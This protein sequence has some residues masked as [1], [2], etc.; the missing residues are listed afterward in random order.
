M[1][2]SGDTL[3]ITT[4]SGLSLYNLRTHQYRR[5]LY[6]EKDSFSVQ[7]NNLWLLHRVASGEVIVS[8]R[9]LSRYDAAK[10][11]FY[12]KRNSKNKDSLY[13]Y[14]D[15]NASHYNE[16]GKKLWVESG[17][18]ALY[19]Y[20]FDTKKSTRHYYSTDT[21]IKTITIL[22]PDTDGTLWIGT[23]KGLI[24]YNTKT[25]SGS[26]VTLPT[27]L[28]HVTNVH[29]TKNILWVTTPAEIIKINKATG[30]TE[31]FDLRSALPQCYILGRAMILDEKGNIWLGTNKGFCIIDTARFHGQGHAAQPRLVSFTVFDKEKLFDQPFSEIQKIVLTN[32]E[33]FFSFG[34]SSFNFQPQTI[35]YA[36]K[37]EGFD[38]D[39]NN[40]SVNKASYTNVPP[41]SYTLL[42]R[43]T[44][45]SG[46]WENMDPIIVR[47][48]PPFWGTAWFISALVLLLAATAYWLYFLRKRA[49][50]KKN[51]DKTIDYFAN[52]VYG[53]NSVNEICWDIARNCI[54]QLQ[55]RRLR[56]VLMDEERE[57][58]LVQKAAYGPKNPK[59]HEIVNPIDD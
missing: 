17:L 22:T 29:V 47:V 34:F 41:G 13:S 27:N 7:A 49:Q 54:S 23:P 15:I 37:L 40:T 18:G 24:R 31:T 21:S 1:I 46:G 5:Y 10:E 14:T 6:D 19:E 28:Q 4:A 45:G 55:F 36:Y 25:R 58:K 39:W 56:G 35:Q 53:E 52:S 20:D 57:N 33:N 9:G 3:F 44:N 50:A 8:G 30:Y 11:R 16:T 2:R 42:I 38:K 59:G 12:H 43:A 51:I 48:K 32:K 26:N